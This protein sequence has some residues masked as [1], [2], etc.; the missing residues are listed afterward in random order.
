MQVIDL[1]YSYHDRIW[2]PLGNFGPK[3]IFSRPR[4]DNYIL[5]YEEG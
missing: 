2:Q 4:C 1:N 5:L 3:E